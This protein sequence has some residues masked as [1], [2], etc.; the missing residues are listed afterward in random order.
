MYMK[1]TIILNG[2]KIEYEL[3]RKRVKNIN[4]RV[5]ADGVHVSASRLVPLALVESFLQN[6]AEYILR[7]LDRMQSR[8]QTAPKA[9]AFVNGSTVPYMGASLPLTITRG[10]KNR[11]ELAGASILLTV[12]DPS[13]GELCR[14]TMEKWL[15]ERCIE[16]VTKTCQ[17]VY[18]HFARRGVQYPELKFRRMT[19]RWGSCQPTR[20]ILTFNTA[21]ISVPKECMEY[22]VV[23]EFAHFLQPNHSALFYSEVEKLLPDWKKRR[24]GLGGYEL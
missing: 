15:R 19:S 21:L 7:A 24:K 22:V 14:K 18:P 3:E 23:H 2:R 9:L 13:D 5:R 8:E 12:K 1:K 16:A 4:L 17:A 10:T 20:G 6:N 11:A